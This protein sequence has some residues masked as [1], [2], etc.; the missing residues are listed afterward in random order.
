MKTFFLLSA[1]A[2]LL[3][4]A[5]DCNSKKAVTKYKGRLEV[6]ALCMNYTI[7]V[8]EG[9]IDKNL[10]EDEWKDETTGKTYDNAFGL[11]S[12][13]SFP[14]DIKEKDEFYFVIDTSQVQNCMVCMAYYPTPAKKL[15]IKV[16][17]P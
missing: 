1:F 9:T 6:K 2:T 4:S 10:V 17:N 16:I 5:S 11:A 13:C 3:L 14:A 7:S 12:R 8:L 15:S